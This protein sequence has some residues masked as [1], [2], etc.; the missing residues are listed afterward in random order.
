M[1]VAELLNEQESNF[2]SKHKI[3]VAPYKVNSDFINEIE[4]N[5]ITSEMLESFDYPIFKYKTQ[6][7]LHGIF[8]TNNGSFYTGGYK[9]IIV[10]KN[11]SIGIRY[12]AI[13]IEKKRLIGR[14][15]RLE[16]SKF[17]FEINSTETII[18]TYLQLNE[19]NIELAKNIYNLISDKNYI[20]F[21][22]LYISKSMFGNYIVFKLHLN[23][24][25]EKNLYSF[26]SE[27]LQKEYSEQT[28]LEIKEKKELEHKAYMEKI[29]QENQIRKENKLKEYESFKTQ[30]FNN[31]KVRFI[32]TFAE[33]RYLFIKLES[34]IGLLHI[35]KKRGRLMGYVETVKDL[36]NIPTTDINNHKRKSFSEKRIQ[37]IKDRLNKDY[38]F[39]LV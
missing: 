6:I 18:Y 20:G 39:K 4:S 19:N 3:N 14:I 33:G 35:F 13:D 17:N 10:N 32:K 38:Y 22:Q 1:K 7:T 26:I 23:A 36:T 15:L 5:G 8:Q 21:K 30:F 12:S 9:N 29:E 31:N 37:T 25:Y 27:L 24:I 16:N 34:E 2:D 11:K 28:Y